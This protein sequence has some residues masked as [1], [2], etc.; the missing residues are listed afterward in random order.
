MASTLGRGDAHAVVITEPVDN[1]VGMWTAQALRRDQE[2]A[3][4]GAVLEDELLEELSLLLL[5]GVLGAPLVLDFDSDFD[6][7]AVSVLATSAT[8]PPAPERLSVR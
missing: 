8:V 4:A 1:G 2:A 6:S 3:V 5:L 7:L